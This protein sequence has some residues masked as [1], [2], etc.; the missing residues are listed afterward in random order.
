MVRCILITSFL[1]FS[2]FSKSQDTSFSK[3]LSTVT[4]KSVTKKSTDLAVISSIR[5]SSVVSD[6]VSIEFIK[7]TPDRNASDALKRVSGV[8]IQGDRF[9]LVRG[10]ADR[11]NSA[12]LNKTPLPST[13]PDRRAFSFDI[14]PT[15]LIDN[16][17]VVK[18]ASANLP[19]DWTG[20]FIQVSTKEVSDNFFSLSFGT[21]LGLVSTFNSFN[22]I[23][24]FQ[25]P[26]TFPSTYKYRTSSN[27][28]R[29]LYTKQFENPETKYFNTTP[30]LNGGLSFGYKKNKW[31]SLLSSTIR[32]SY[33]I[34]YT[35]RKDYQSSSE[36]AYEYNDTLFTKR[37][38][39]NTLANIT[40]IG[41]NKYSWKTLI[42]YQNEDSRLIRTGE[43]YDNVQNV[44]SNSSNHLRTL[45]AN[46]QIEGKIKTFDFNIGY[47]YVF[48]E[49]PDYRVNPITKSL[50]VNEPYSTAWRDTYRFWSVMDEN[51]YNGNVNKQFGTFRVGS[52]YLRK[53]RYFNA[54][55]FRYLSSDM[56]DEVT[57]NTDKYGANF[58]LTSAYST[59]ENE[60]GNWKVNTGVRVEYN[61]FDVLTSDFSGQKIQVGRKYLDLLPST[62][63]SYNLDKT[64]Y[65]LSVS[66]T[67]SRPE[68]REVSNFAYYDFVRNAQILGNV[69]LE[70]SDVY[71]IDLKYEYYP[72]TGENISLS[73]FN[74]N[75][76]RPIEQVVADGSVPSNLLLTYSNPSSAILYGIEMEIR[77]KVTSWLDFY[78]NAS[79]MNSE[80]SVNGTKRQLQGQSNYVFN[81]GTNAKVKNSSINVTYNRVGDRISAVGFQGYPDIFENSRD[82]IDLT[83]L[84]KIKKG[85]IKVSIS[86]ILGQPSVYYQKF[87]NR[88]L[89]K[90]NNEQIL[91]ISLNLNL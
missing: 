20:G 12:F 11:Y 30:N 61:T 24:P 32:N 52:S 25:F 59:Y 87:M 40:Y 60:F 14:I 1:L 41:K 8:T 19:G 78:V 86:D 76:I 70:K 34:N 23:K 89:I 69:K 55:V 56:L 13:E 39:I 72:R 81:A 42:N 28:D 75:F 79:L 21:G 10:L 54:R 80:V 38:S 45:V 18:S 71:N 43:N 49:Q 31:N 50:G 29:R 83:I 63:I 48:R 4:V 51:T 85:D 27:G 7:K 53:V 67:L 68:F 47:N 84:H 82:V 6:G 58:D 5:N 44:K 36:L 74:K 33:V 35:N 2:K 3:Q 26:S 73:I 16:I 65:R 62:N 64:K 88:K 46:S 15:A 77:K 9:V 66:K 17:I 22:T 90:T 91:S 37:F 57:N